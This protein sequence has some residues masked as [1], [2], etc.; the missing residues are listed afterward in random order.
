MTRRLS[1]SGCRSS[2]PAVFRV[3]VLF[4]NPAVLCAELR[5]GQ[6]C[7]S[8][9]VG[10]FPGL[11]AKMTTF[12]DAPTTGVNNGGAST[13]PGR[14]N[15]V[16][17]RDCDVW[18]VFLTSDGDVSDGTLVRRQRQRATTSSGAK[19]SGEVIFLHW[20]CFFVHCKPVNR[21]NRLTFLRVTRL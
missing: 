18:R 3:S 17:V 19:L 12:S 7:W 9:R 15:R 8:G 1:P 14:N 2:C 4:F 16:D 13:G 11:Y 6:N 10:C 5:V 20:L 21:N